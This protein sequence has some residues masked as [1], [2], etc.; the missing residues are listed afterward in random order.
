M[1]KLH[2]GIGIDA[3]TLPTVRAVSGISTTFARLGAGNYR[4]TL[5]NGLAR[6]EMLCNVTV[7]EDITGAS[8]VGIPAVTVGATVTVDVKTY[9]GSSL[10]DLDFDLLITSP[11]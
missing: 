8:G 1:M 4:F 5:D 6:N 7:N 2:A 10:A 3:G 11:R 9:F